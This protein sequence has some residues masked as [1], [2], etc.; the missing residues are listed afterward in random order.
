MARSVEDAALLLAAIAGPDPADP[1]SL[2]REPPGDWPV[3]SP[4]LRGLRVGLDEAF[5]A[6]D[7]DEKTA[8]S[9][10]AAADALSAMGTE[11]VPCTIPMLDEIETTFNTIFSIELTA[12]HRAFADRR[13]EYGPGFRT[14]LE[15]SEAI[16]AEA[17]VQA[18]LGRAAFREAI[19]ELFREVDVLLTPVNPMA[20]PR[21]V[22]VPEAAADVPLSFFRFT[23]PWNLAAVPA[24]SV[25]WGFD[26]RGLPNAVQ[27]IGP[28]GEEARI[29]SVAHALEARAPDRG[30]HPPE[31]SLRG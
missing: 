7:T 11:I 22:D 28:H 13:D 16:P 18:N 4:E 5:I 23:Y 1:T 9:A 3:L 14:L 21:L 25:P 6:R 15:S 17:Y 8:A 2:G 12:A 26:S 24:L 29:L 31:P 19:G 30:R 10:H 27:I 20:A